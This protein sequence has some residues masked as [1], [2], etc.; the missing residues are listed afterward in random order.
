MIFIL[1]VQVMEVKRQ[2]LEKMP[3]KKISQLLWMMSM[4]FLEKM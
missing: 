1:T 4:N 3:D 2:R